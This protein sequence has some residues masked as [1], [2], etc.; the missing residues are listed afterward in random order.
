MN[1]ILYQ[2]NIPNNFNNN[3]NNINNMNYLNNT[4]YLNNN[5]IFND[6]LIKLQNI[7]ND[8]YNKKQIDI[9]INQL[10]NII[11]IINNIINDNKNNINQ[12]K[13]YLS[14]KI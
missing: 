4:I 9:I 12:L 3:L 2:N 6:I 7:V 11:I 1:P 14:Q 13:Q 10:K 5:Q 8:I